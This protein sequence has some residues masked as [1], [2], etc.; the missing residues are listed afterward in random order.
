MEGY[1]GIRNFIIKA[2]L[3]VGMIDLVTLNAE[4]CVDKEE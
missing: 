1:N 2:F 4:L 3:V